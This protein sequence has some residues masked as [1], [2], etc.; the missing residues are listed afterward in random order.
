LL[1][2]LATNASF[3]STMATCNST[4]CVPKVRSLCWFHL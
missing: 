1:H 4:F 3:P 2:W